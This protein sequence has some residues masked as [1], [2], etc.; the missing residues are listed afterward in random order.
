[1]SDELKEVPCID[2]V[3]PDFE[4]KVGDETYRL[5][6]DLRSVAVF[7][8]A[9]GRNMIIDGIG[10]ET[11]NIVIAL[12]AGILANHPEVKIEDVGNWFT[13]KTSRSFYRTVFDAL[14]ASLPD[15]EGNEV[16]EARNP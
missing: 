9:T 15:V 12:W 10:T 16:A 14:K 4:F 2:P 1:M 6:Y 7:E 8:R 3:A 13:L 11:T 5:R